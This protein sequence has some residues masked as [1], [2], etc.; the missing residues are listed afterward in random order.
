IGPTGPTGADGPQGLIGPTGPDGATG[1]TGPTGAG[2]I[3]PFA[4]GLPVAPTALLTGLVGLPAVVSFGHS[5]VLPN[6]LGATIDLTGAA[7]LMANMSF[8]MPRDGVITDI[9]AY[10]STVV[11]LSLIGGAA[12]VTAQLYA[13]TTPDNTFSPV[14]GT[15]VTLAPAFSGLV[16]IGDIASG[17][18][19]GLNIPVTAETRLL[20]VFSVTTTGLAIAT[21]VTGYASGGVNI[22]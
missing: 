11:A 16:A 14:A 10:F 22:A 4:S 13:S 2:A 18:L 3:I 9:T 17:S 5:T 12:T 6:I 7:G 1:P 19:T 15:A 20:L 21:T 8:S